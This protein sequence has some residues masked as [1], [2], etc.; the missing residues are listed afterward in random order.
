MLVASGSGFVCCV[1]MNEY[2]EVSSEVSCS[3]DR[4]S[5]DSDDGEE[6]I[7]DS[8]SRAAIVDKVTVSAQAWERIMK[9]PSPLSCDLLQASFESKGW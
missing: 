8:L 4:V 5:K 3:A 1:F 2:S 7:G 9:Q 6:G